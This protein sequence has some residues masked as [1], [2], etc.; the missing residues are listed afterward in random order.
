MKIKITKVPQKSKEEGGFL[1][2]TQD[3]YANGGILLRNTQNRILV[4]P[5]GTIG[6]FDWGGNLPNTHDDTYKGGFPS[7][8]MGVFAKGGYQSSIGPTLGD[9]STMYEELTMG[10]SFP[11]DNTR[12]AIT[13]GA[14]SEILNKVSNNSSNK[15]EVTKRIIELESVKNKVTHN[16]KL[17]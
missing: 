11:G 12:Y 4:Y 15:K 6:R 1:F 17:L 16:L 10:S 2:D 9:N 8:G 3:T 5:D 7:Q 13:K 14:T